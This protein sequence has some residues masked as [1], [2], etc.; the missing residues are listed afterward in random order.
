LALQEG[1]GLAEQRLVFFSLNFSLHIASQVQ[2]LGL[3]GPKE[4]V[5]KRK[6]GFFLYKNVILRAYTCLP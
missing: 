5:V 2:Y 3:I 6:E 4:V 1:R